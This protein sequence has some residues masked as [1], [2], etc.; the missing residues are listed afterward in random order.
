MIRKKRGIGLAG[1]TG[2]WV[3]SEACAA[4]PTALGSATLLSRINLM[5]ALPI[6]TRQ[7]FSLL[8]P[9]ASKLMRF[10][11]RSPIFKKE[12]AFGDSLRLPNSFDP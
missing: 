7:G 5:K 2:E 1:F 4:Q 8:V 9:T 11:S 12:D 10:G 6:H 3:F